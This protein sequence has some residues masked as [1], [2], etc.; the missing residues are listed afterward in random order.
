MRFHGGFADDEVGGD[1][2]VGE[3][4]GEPQQ[5]VVFPGG[6]RCQLGRGGPGVGRRAGEGVDQPDRDRRRE[7]CVSRGGVLNGRDQVLAGG[8]LEQEAARPGAQCLVDV[9][10]EVE[11]G[12]HDDLRPGF[13]AAAS[14]LP[15]GLEAVHFGHAHVHQDHVGLVLGGGLDGLGPVGGLGDHGDPV[16]SVEDDAKPGPDQFLVIND[17]YPYL[18]CAGHGAGSLA[19]TVNP[20]S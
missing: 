19:L 17:E 20:L 18:A 2:G 10:V 7:Q 15:G 14:D 16:G 1:L 4:A 11:G 8:V 3:A 9:V 5:D 12:E 13:P 6:Q